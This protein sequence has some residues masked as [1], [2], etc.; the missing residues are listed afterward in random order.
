MWCDYN[1]LFVFKHW[2][3][4]KTQRFATT[5]WMHNKAIFTRQKCWDDLFLEMFKLGQIESLSKCH[6][7][8]SLQKSSTSVWWVTNVIFIISVLRSLCCDSS[9]EQ[10]P[11]ILVLPQLTGSTSVNSI[12]MYFV[13]CIWLIRLGCLCILLQHSL[14]RIFWKHCSH[15][16]SPVSLQISQLDPP[17]FKCISN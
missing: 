11:P 14:H 12:Y 6:N 5:S 9:I 13:R 17:P 2:R 3:E 8:W 10:L 7:R 16:Y 4:L 1:G 15:L